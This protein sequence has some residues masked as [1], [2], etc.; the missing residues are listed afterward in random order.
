[1]KSRKPWAPKTALIACALFCDSTLEIV[2]VKARKFCLV[3]WCDRE[4]LPQ[5]A[6][7]LA[8]VD[9]LEV[10]E[11]LTTAAERLLAVHRGEQRGGGG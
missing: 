1:M 10:V 7:N 4:E 6:S 5:Y 8:G 11:M 9:R 3:S 2:D